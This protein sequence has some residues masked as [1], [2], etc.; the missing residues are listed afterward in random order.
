MNARVQQS[1]LG[2]PAPLRPAADMAPV[3]SDVDLDFDAAAD[4]F[5]ARHRADGAMRDLAVMDLRT[6]GIAPVK[7]QF[8][9]MPLAG[10]EPPRQLRSN[11]FSMLCT[12][13]GAPAEFIRDKLP[14]PLQLATLNYLMAQG[15]KPGSA[16]LRLRGDEISAIVSER[17]AP[18]DA[19]Q[20]VDTLRTAL[21]RHGVLDSVRVRAVATGLTDAIRLILPSEAVPVK[22]GDV[23]FVGLDVSS[24]SFGKSAV[25]VHGMVMRLVCANG[26]RSPS[27]TGNLSL[28][29]VGETQR[30]RDGLTEGVATALTHARG[31]M[32]QWKVAV[33]SY[34]SN[35]ANYIDGL[36]DLS[37]FEQQAVR[38]ELGAKK[39]A[40]LPDRGSVYDL[41]NAITATAHHVEPARRLELET[42]AGRVLVHQ[43]SG[44]RS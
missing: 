4:R 41:V 6:W 3:W 35:L 13:L 7:D 10:H 5:V 9:L 18:L 24:S 26:L 29:H 2:L 15:E 1:A 23:S 11:A 32:G 16:M 14:A 17:Y 42:I 19:E 36:R 34:I 21:A 8:T 22:V 43:T 40:E 33:S 38:L 12:R 25:H 20:L 28:R 30:L 37:Q 27:S 39:P 44:G 31:L